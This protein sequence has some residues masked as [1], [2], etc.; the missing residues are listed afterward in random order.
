MSFSFLTEVA[1]QANV[2]IDQTSH[3]RLADFGLLTII[4]DPT[5]HLSSSSYAQG[6]T[7]RWM[8]P[9]RIAPRRFGLEDS[10][11]T[12]PSDC[13]A[14]GMVIYETISGNLP[15]HE[16]TDLA[17]F[18]KVMEGERPPRRARFPEDLWKMMELCWAPQPNDRPSIE[19]VL[20]HLE[21]IPHLLESPSPGADEGMDEDGGD[22]D[23]ATNSSGVLNRTSDV[24]WVRN[25]LSNN[26]KENTDIV[27]PQFML[28]AGGIFSNSALDISATRPDN[29]SP[30]VP[31]PI[32]LPSE[33][34]SGVNHVSTIY[35]KKT[36]TPNST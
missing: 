25:N 16:D 21:S 11:P 23:I 36:R 6:G 2:L 32:I 24:D 29:P 30:S 34:F 4:S 17:V 10:R 15:F 18:V 3:A 22:W 20:R 7:A 26:G 33:F 12:K 9:E 19:G 27:P 1:Y 8:S 13:Y 5:N 31:S 35:S 28:A 14:L